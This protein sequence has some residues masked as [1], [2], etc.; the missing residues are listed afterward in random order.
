MEIEQKKKLTHAVIKAEE[1][2]S[3]RIAEDMHDSIAQKMVAAKL[4]LEA[5]GNGVEFAESEKNNIQ[6]H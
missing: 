5:L 2:E 3:K 1:D 4:N 6:Q